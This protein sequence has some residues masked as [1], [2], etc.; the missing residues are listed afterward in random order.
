MRVRVDGTSLEPFARSRPIF[1]SVQTD[2]TRLIWMEASLTTSPPF[3]VAWLD[4]AAVADDA[5]DAGAVQT[6]PAVDP[7]ASSAFMT[8]F[9]VTPTSTYWFASSSTECPG[10]GAACV[11]AAPNT[12]L[13]GYTVVHA[14]F[15]PYSI[16]N[17]SIDDRYLYP[18]TSGGKIYRVD[19][20]QPD[21]GFPSDLI[22]SPGNVTI[23]AVDQTNVYWSDNSAGTI[24]STPKVPSDAGP[25]VFATLQNVPGDI[26]AE[27]G[28]V[29][30][31]NADGIVT[32]PQAGCPNGT[33]KPRVVVAEPG[34]TF[35]TTT[36]KCF[37]YANSSS[38]TIKVVGR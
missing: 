34:I 26:L 15:A 19:T 18:W 27:N 22:A 37:Y 38:G 10:V 14:S 1:A 23:D 11:Y 4:K 2:G 32:C 8:G 35:F 6:A 16:G 36:P 3:Q 9:V 20:S 17:A 25:T 13:A 28:S 29:Y 5:G 24:Y 30:W 7:N 31:A 12:S 21:A 33:D